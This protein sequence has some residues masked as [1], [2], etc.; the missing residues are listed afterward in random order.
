MRADYVDRFETDWTGGLKRLVSGGARFTNAA[1]PYLTTITCAGHATIATGTFPHTHGIIQNTWWDRERGRSMTCTEDP[2]VSGV[3]YG[4]PP[5]VGDSAWR[6][7]RPTFADTYRTEGRAHVVTLALKD[8]SA[9]MLAGHGG[10]AVTW[11]SDPIESWTTSSAFAK[12][13][14]PAVKTFVDAHPIAEDFGKSWTLALPESKYPEPDDVPSE[15]PPQG[16]TRTFPHVLKGTASSPDQTYLMQWERSPFA[17][18]YVGRFAIALVDAFALGRHD[19]T[20]VLAVS[21][22]TPDLAGHNFG[23]DSREEHDIY[24]RLDRT[25][26]ALLDHLDATVGRGQWTAALSADH[27]VLPIPDQLIATG[28]EAGR[29]SNATITAALEAKLRAALGG[30]G[31]YVALVYANDIYFTR[32]VYDRLKASPPLFDSV[33]DALRATP[34][35]ARVFRGE[36]LREPS[37]SDALQRAAALSYFPGR[38]GDLVIAPKP[39]WM[40]AATGTT[41]GNAIHEDQHVPLVLFG[42]GIKA[43][44]YD[45]R[46]T[47]ADIAPTLA[48]IGG[49][50]MAKVEGRVLK[51]ALIH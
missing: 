40:F 4:A 14:L 9:I 16:W 1:Y 22:S 46:V 32:G 39:G 20:D 43:G 47:P 48:A 11:V 7:A 3:S 10:D 25:I 38:S 34:G 45:D 49:L 6:L 17:N 18:D 44:R 35:I 42:A 15:A 31:P 27:G 29:L 24:V 19:H 26:G 23:P 21:F 36:D 30:E 28:K 8:R 50:T 12:A 2:Q 5:K 51:V 41:H 33:V 13:P 37:T